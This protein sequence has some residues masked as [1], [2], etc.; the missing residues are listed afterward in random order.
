M[1]ILKKSNYNLFIAQEKEEN[2]EE[3]I[4]K[5]NGDI[6]AVCNILSAKVEILSCNY[7]IVTLPVGFVSDLSKYKEV[8][9]I[10]FSK[11]IHYMLKEDLEY[12]GVTYVNHPSGYHLNGE[13]VAIGI[14]DS[15]IDY[16]HKDF[17]KEDGSS[18]ILY[19]W[20][21]NGQENPPQGFLYGTEY[22]Q[23][24]INEALKE[25]TPYSII[26]C[27]DEIGHGTAVAGIA[28]GN[29]LSNKEQQRGVASKASLIIVK[30]GN[31]K[32]K[33]T[34]RTTEIMRAVKYILDKAQQ[35]NMPLS[36]NISYGTNNG[37]HDGNSLF[38]SFLNEIC[39]KWKTVISVAAGNEGSAGHHFRTKLESDKI[40]VIEFVY[41]GNR[42][43]FYLTGWKSFHDDMTFELISPNG[44]SSGSLSQMQSRISL[45]IDGF[46]VEIFFY[47]PTHY[48]LNQEFR[49]IFTNRTSFVTPGVWQLIVR[50]KT[51]IDGFFNIWMPTVEDVGEEAF[52]LRPET[53][54]TITLPATTKNVISVGGYYSDIGNFAEFSGR[55]YNTMKK[56]DITAPAVNIYTCKSGGGYDVY[57]GTSMA[58]PFVCGSAA[59]IM[60]WGIVNGND[61][62]LYGQKVKAVLQKSAGRNTYIS[63][64]NNEWGYGTLNLSE[65]MEILTFQPKGGFYG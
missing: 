23:Q 10:E 36:I 21:Q 12:T 7:A 11:D 2:Y 13:G 46:L 40:E 18:R 65:A 62:F 63:Y 31:Y 34:T 47:Q 9:Y 33:T 29:G 25:L 45:S 14:I 16:T 22:I 60:E 37:S 56:P 52:F 42:K 19:L 58:A 27:H 3:I 57:T 39:N 17:C 8:E 55:G 41:G 64:P 51:I 49:F 35:H 1:T 61:P 26:N 30:L 43:E 24:H 50:S 38:E 28:A 20:D 59:L 44:L 53:Q 15:G 48:N 5:F 54:F 4:V 32:N 6:T